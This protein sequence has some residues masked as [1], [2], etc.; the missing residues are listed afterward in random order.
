MGEMVRVRRVG[1]DVSDN[2]TCKWKPSVFL[3]FLDEQ[4]SKDK[5]R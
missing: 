3:S 4:V 5:T 2:L 1:R